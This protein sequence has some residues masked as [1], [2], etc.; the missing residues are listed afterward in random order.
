MSKLIDSKVAARQDV[1]QRFN[2]DAA[3][4]TPGSSLLLPLDVW[5][6]YRSR[7]L[8]HDGALG[9][10][11]SPSDDVSTL[12]DDLDRL[13]LITISFPAFTDGRGYSQARLLRERLGYTGEIRAVGDVLIDQLLYLRRCGFDSFDL[14]ADQSI[15]D[16]KIAV[17]SL[18]QAYQSGVGQSPLFRRRML[19]AQPVQV[20]RISGLPSALPSSNES[21]LGA[22]DRSV[23]LAVAAA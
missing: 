1:W 22:A 23:S 13:S 8:A 19:S 3:T 17:G 2:G 5:R 10:Q 9:I 21:E 18:T 14:R 7:W 4:V 20:V 12:A 16:A 6:E 11:L 15:E